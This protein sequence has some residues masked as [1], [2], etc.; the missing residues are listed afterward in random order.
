MPTTCRFVHVAGSALT[1]ALLLGCTTP[2]GGPAGDGPAARAAPSAGG[3]SDPAHQQ[4]T[5]TSDSPEAEHTA[6]GAPHQPPLSPAAERSSAQQRSEQSSPARRLIEAAV[7]LR[8]SSE[9]AAALERIAARTD[10]TA[11][12]QITLIDAACQ[13]GYS[14]RITAVLLTLAENPT[15]TPAGRSHLRE[16]LDCIAFSSHRQRVLDAL[17]GESP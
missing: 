13:V 6:Q 10:L 17:G 3:R 9:R 14:E 4:P 2:G 16:S 11:D 12:E 5:A 1:V 15:L 7:K 8:F